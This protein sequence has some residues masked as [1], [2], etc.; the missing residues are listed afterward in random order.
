MTRLCA[1]WGRLGCVSGRERRGCGEQ[2]VG[3]G[4]EEGG[5]PCARGG[6]AGSGG[7]LSFLRPSVGYGWRRR[8]LRFAAGI[9]AL[10]H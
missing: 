7:D 3:S 1:P 9:G 4:G 10:N 5:L 6:G 2:I 8:G